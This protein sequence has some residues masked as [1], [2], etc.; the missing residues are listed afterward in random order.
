LKYLCGSDAVGGK[1]TMTGRVEGGRWCLGR[2]VG[3]CGGGAKGQ[4]H[5]WILKESLEYFFS[6][7]RKR[8]G[9][10]RRE[11]MIQE[12]VYEE[13]EKNEIYTRSGEARAACL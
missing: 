11:L 3:G 4:R 1:L 10:G 5:Y 8:E 6:V 9:G 13:P 12:W 7:V 2:C